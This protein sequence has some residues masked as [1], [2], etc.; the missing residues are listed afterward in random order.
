MTN[1]QA[2]TGVAQLESIDT[3]IDA[4]RRNAQLY[5]ELLK[6]VP[7]ITFP[8]E[9]DNVKNVY[10]MYSVLVEDSFPMD[11]D[12]LRSALKEKGIDTRDFFYPLSSQPVGQV[13]ANGSYSVAEDVSTRGMYLPS[14]LALTEEQLTYVT[15]TIHE[16]AAQ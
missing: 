6:D 1:V 9:H 16:L 14:G 4:R 11:R 7:G 2:A 15:D 3:F 13:F 12:A 8:V 10:W 5:N